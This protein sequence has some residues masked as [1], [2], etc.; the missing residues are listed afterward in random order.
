[1]NAK[2]INLAD[3]RSNKVLKNVAKNN[4]EGKYVNK[5]KEALKKMTKE[6]LLKIED[7]L[8]N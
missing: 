6:D 2:I 1:M 7:L 5:F 4:S 8:E 3:F